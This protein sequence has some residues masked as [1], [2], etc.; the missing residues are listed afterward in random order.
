MPVSHSPPTKKE[1]SPT[2]VL[3]ASRLDVAQARLRS[4]SARSFSIPADL[5]ALPRNPP[6]DRPAPRRQSISSKP[7]GDPLKNR[8][9]EF[10]RNS[11]QARKTKPLRF[12]QE[13]EDILSDQVCSPS[14]RSL[15]TINETVPDEFETQV[16]SPDASRLSLKWDNSANGNFTFLHR[17]LN[18]SSP[19][20]S[21][22]DNESSVLTLQNPHTELRT[23]PPEPQQNSDFPPDLFQLDLNS[24]NQQTSLR[25]S[26][27]LQQPLSSPPT[28]QFDFNL[29]AGRTDDQSS[30]LP[31][32]RV[33][34]LDDTVRTNDEITRVP[35]ITPFTPVFSPAPQSSTMDVQTPDGATGLPTDV[36]THQ[37]NL[38]AGHQDHAGGHPPHPAPQP[39]DQS[40]L[41]TRLRMRT[42]CEAWIDE[43]SSYD[44]EYMDPESTRDRLNDAVA[45]KKELEESLLILRG[46][47]PDVSDL[48]AD[49]KRTKLFFISF[50]RDCQAHIR[51]FTPLPTAQPPALSMTS[52][53]AL[54][55]TL[56]PAQKHKKKRVL[57]YESQMLRDLD[58]ITDEIT[59]LFSNIP[60]NDNGIKQVEERFASYSKRAEVIVK[61]GIS[62][63]NDAAD[64][65]LEVEADALESHVRKVKAAL[66]DGQVQ[67]GEA[68][69]RNQLYG[70]A[71]TFKSNDIKPPTFSGDGESTTDYFSFTKEYEEFADNR[72]YTRTQHLHTLKKT[73]LTGTA[74][75]SCEEME[76]VEEIFRYLKKTYGNPNILL[77]NKVKEFKKL[78]ACPLIPDK[79]R[80]WMI[81]AQQQ[82]K[83]LMKVAQEHDILTDLHY[84][85]ILNIIHTSMP[86]KTQIQFR[87]AMEQLD[88]SSLTRAEI[89]SETVS[90][91][92]MEVNKAT[93]NIKFNYL[94]GVESSEKIKVVDRNKVTQKPP[95]KKTY[96]AIPQPPN[97]PPPSGAAPPLPNPPPA[98]PLPYSNP[99]LLFMPPPPSLNM[100]RPKCHIA[101]FVQTSTNIFIIAKSSSAHQLKIG[102]K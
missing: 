16:D 14:K 45:Q 82:L 55:K 62:L 8:A 96:S 18:R 64:V 42:V 33:V 75:L 43:F 50:I 91:L 38:H 47:D 84:S 93:T 54:E 73:C 101:N 48:E 12:I 76:S 56:T 77:N 24:D 26:P 25:L 21:D 86:Y 1:I 52:L 67:L 99:Q 53:P 85:D 35:G 28:N 15:Q 83:Y 68:K 97:N 27:P 69:S 4:H 61:D 51:K 6:I 32:S 39:P 5:D 34:D 40:I 7:K 74:K 19:R 2:P 41:K 22:P 90:F 81:R 78:G 72:S 31:L 23:A 87:E 3:R 13:S 11:S 71:S 46:I 65:D 70:T 89:F 58:Q 102:S 17:E 88:L 94:I 63:T 66:L 29:F 30:T 37:P 95:V 36:I 10:K 9:S 49:C 59:I 79:K 92:D 60:S 80:D 20:F 100:T 98:P 57:N 44:L